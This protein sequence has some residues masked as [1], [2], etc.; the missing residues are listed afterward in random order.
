MLGAEWDGC[1]MTLCPGYTQ[2]MLKCKIPLALPP[3]EVESIICYLIPKSHYT[4][5]KHT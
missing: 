1:P 2:E 3:V 5:Q 4:Q